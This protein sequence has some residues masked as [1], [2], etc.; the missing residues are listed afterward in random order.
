MNSETDDAKMKLLDAMANVGTRLVV[1]KLLAIAENST[2]STDLRLA[3]I[4]GLQKTEKALGKKV[5]QNAF[6]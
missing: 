3:A 1:S 4:H 5:R 6:T 2:V